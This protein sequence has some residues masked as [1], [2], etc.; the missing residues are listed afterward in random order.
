MAEYEKALRTG[1]GNEV[2]NYAPMQHGWMVARADLKKQ[3]GLKEF[4]RGYSEAGGELFCEASLTLSRTRE[5]KLDHKYE[6]FVISLW[7]CVTELRD[8]S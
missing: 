2:E 6:S 4:A 1:K 5:T 3:E 8:W 7:H